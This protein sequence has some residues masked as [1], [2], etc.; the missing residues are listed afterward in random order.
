MSCTVAK[1][2]FFKLFFCCSTVF[3]SLT[4]D[5]SQRRDLTPD[6]ELLPRLL[7]LAFNVACI[8]PIYSSDHH[9][10]TFDLCAFSL[11]KIMCYILGLIR[12]RGRE[13]GSHLQ[14]LPPNI[15]PNPSLVMVSSCVTDEQ[16]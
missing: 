1:M 8:P 7:V 2:N 12:A 13:E 16:Q 4:A 9:T 11:K 14:H 5:R 6:T 10:Y 15:L 3:T